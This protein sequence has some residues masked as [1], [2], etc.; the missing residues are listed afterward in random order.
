M[1]NLHPVDPGSLFVWHLAENLSGKG[2][3]T[4]SQADVNIAVFPDRGAA[5]CQRN[6]LPLEGT[7]FI[8]S[9]HTYVH[10]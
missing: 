7:A 10:T 2:G 8:K 6:L 4:R 3:H 5:K 9:T 1:P